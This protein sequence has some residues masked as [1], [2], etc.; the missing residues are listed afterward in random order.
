MLD[1]DVERAVNG[2]E[3]MADQKFTRCPGCS[4]VFRVSEAQLALREGQVRCGHCRAVFDANDHRV[5]LDAAPPPDFDATDELMMGRPTV[6]LRS[7]DALARVDFGHEAQTKGEPADEETH[8]AADAAAG[9]EANAEARAEANV[10]ARA[11]ANVEAR[12]EGAAGGTQVRDAA[13]EETDGARGTGEA[14]PD[15]AAANADVAPTGEVLEGDVDPHQNRERIGGDPT[16][17]DA[18]NEVAPMDAPTA[19]E[20]ASDLAEATTPAVPVE[21]A[22][23]R[24]G[25]RFE[26]NKGTSQDGPPRRLYAIAVGALVVGLALQAVLEFRD[27]LAARLPVTRPMLESACGL[28][29][30][31]IEPLRDA[32]ALSID[33]S[34]LQADPAHRG[35]LLLS[36]TVRN[37]A[38]HAVAF[39]YL[40]LTLTDSSDGVVARRAFPPTDYAGGTAD[41]HQGIPANGE[42]VIRMFLDASATQQAGYRLYLFY[43]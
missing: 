27:A 40:E 16:T 2:P 29:G 10:E 17:A 28:L 7:A 20:A 26:W 23:V 41:P 9:A 24:P 34:D 42:R 13:R 6:M 8:P 32:S 14:T 25:R 22:A 5:S 33:A 43:P 1:G 30:C 3:R 39:P 31:T 15:D 37:R 11:E 4:T 19:D 36:A 35:L 18:A 21:L 38:A 12:A